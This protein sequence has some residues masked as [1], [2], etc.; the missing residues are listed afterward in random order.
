MK[1]NQTILFIF[2]GLGLLLVNNLYLYWQFFQFN[3]SEFL[4]NTIGIALF[5]EV[6]GL[7][8]L[9]ALYFKKNPIGK[10]KWYWLIILSIFGSLL[11]GLPFY[12]WLNT[13]NNNRKI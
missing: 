1:M 7:M 11:F 5:I 10:Y 8:F 12:Y 2:S 9:L 6:F 13:K 3:F 4:S